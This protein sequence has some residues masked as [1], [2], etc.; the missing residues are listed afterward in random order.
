MIQNIVRTISGENKP[1]ITQRLHRSIRKCIQRYITDASLLLCFSK[2]GSAITDTT[3]QPENADK[4]A[5][6]NAVK[7]ADADADKIADANADANADAEDADVEDVDADA[8]ATPEQLDSAVGNCNI[9]ETLKKL[10][11]KHI[12]RRNR[13]F[14]IERHNGKDTVVV[15]RPSSKDP[16]SFVW[17]A[18][19]SKWVD[20]LLPTTYVN[21]MRMYLAA[22][23]SENYK[24]VAELYSLKV[25]KR[26]P[27][28]KT[29]AITSEVRLGDRQLQ[30]LRQ[31]LK[32]EGVLLELSPKVIDKID[33]EVGIRTE[34]GPIFGEYGH[35]E[36]SKEPRVCQ[37]FN[38]RLDKDICREIEGHLFKLI[39]S[40]SDG[41]AVSEIP[42]PDYCAPSNEKGITILLDGDHGDRYF[43]FHAKIHLTSPMERK[44][45]RDLS[46][47]CPIIQ[48]ACCECAKDKY[49]VLKETVMPRLESDIAKVQ[50]SC[51]IVL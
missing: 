9:E 13:A 2:W 14:T 41:A 47:E 39:L 33:Q 23:H 27:T 19:R 6:A 48:I 18:D 5:D 37:F 20:K 25:Q 21:G 38:T 44:K 17:K 29:L 49:I 43:R 7:I 8:D 45:R 50:A 16:N 12:T 26:V 35:F 32:L 3:P 31:Y 36:V 51:A 11:S 46:Y 4:I 40:P 15:A 1:T 30:K 34:T 28:T 22:K 42:S 10:L 24:K